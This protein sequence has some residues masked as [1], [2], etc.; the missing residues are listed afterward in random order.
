MEDFVYLYKGNRCS[1]SLKGIEHLKTKEQ[2]Q[3][4]FKDLVDVNKAWADIEKARP[5]SPLK[6]EKKKV[7]DKGGDK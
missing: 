6:N 1:F 3:E 5:Q 2:F 7:E 4:V